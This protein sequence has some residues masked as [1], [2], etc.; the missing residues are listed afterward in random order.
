MCFVFDKFRTAF[1]F[2]TN[3]QDLLSR[4]I[5]GAKRKRD[6]RPRAAPAHPHLRNQQPIPPHI[7][8]HS[9]RAFVPP[10]ASGPIGALPLDLDFEADATRFPPKLPPVNSLRERAYS[11]SIL[12]SGRVI[13]S[14]LALPRL[15]ASRYLFPSKAVLGS[16]GSSLL[17]QLLLHRQRHVFPADRERI[18]V[19]SARSM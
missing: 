8:V 15:A 9:V 19:G 11:S 6:R 1:C 16:G 2:P 7:S 4:G 17:H 14:A 18:S 12:A 5:R 10:F 3:C 13:L